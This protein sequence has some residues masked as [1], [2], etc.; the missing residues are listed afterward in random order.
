[1]SKETAGSDHTEAQETGV[2]E[3]IL[4]AGLELFA[5][6]G[7]DV[8][9]IREIA[10]AAGVNSAMIYY[11]FQDKEDLYRRLLDHVFATLMQ[12]VRDTAAIEGGTDAA[13]RKLSR[14]YVSFLQ[15]NQ[16][17]ISLMRYELGRGGPYLP[18]LADKYLKHGFSAVRTL[19]EQGIRQG[20]IRDIDPGLGVVSILGMLIFYFIG[21]PVLEHVVGPDGY[22]AEGIAAFLD[23]TLALVSHGLLKNPAG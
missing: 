23:H 10:E 19:I 22:S 7:Y 20:E 17:F 6:R 3:K 4:A 14:M 18:E 21:R 11:Y 12:N 2:R 1:M 9:T 16:N 13:L 8:V 5:A 15:E